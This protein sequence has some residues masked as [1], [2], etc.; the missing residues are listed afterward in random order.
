[1]PET[2]HFCQKLF[3][4]K[5]SKKSKNEWIERLCQREIKNIDLW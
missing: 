4:Q 3:H 5:L 2:I 1:L